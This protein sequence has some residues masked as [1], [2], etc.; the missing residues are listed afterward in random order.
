MGLVHM[1]DGDYRSAAEAFET[2]I[3]L[4]P[5]FTAAKKRAHA[6]RLYLL[7]GGK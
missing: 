5:T 6:V 1:A 7:T 2:A 4:R 3:R